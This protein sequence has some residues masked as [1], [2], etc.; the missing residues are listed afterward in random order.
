MVVY[1]LVMC[2]VY[3]TRHLPLK[4][5]YKLAAGV[6]DLVYIFWP[7][8]RRNVLANMRQ[9]LAP[10]ATDREIRDTARRSFRNYVRLL[11]D[12]ARASTTDPATIE[13]RLKATGWEHLDEAF[14]HGKGV[15]LVASHLGN[16]EVAGLALASRGYHVSAVSESFANERIDRLAVESRA[17]Q[18]IEL[19][20]MEYALKRV[21][22][23]LRRNEAVGLVTD[24]P[25]SPDEGT[26]VQF[27]GRSI[28]WPSGPAVLALRTG[29]KI[30]TGCLVRN[31]DGDY[32]GEM[33][34]A[35]EFETTDDQDADVQRITQ[36]IVSIQEDLIRRYPDQWYMFRRMWPTVR[37]VG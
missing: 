4:S 25:L 18:G 22:T 5:C 15:L 10:E 6:G 1:W 9:V 35:L 24:R 17:A 23:A 36:Q 28:T 14:R 16:W 19:I 37:E 11:V 30:I 33:Y 20:P 29:A 8:G 31:E 12:F 34:P 2:L 27:F 21:Y 3:L 13:A 32:T 7:E 26:P